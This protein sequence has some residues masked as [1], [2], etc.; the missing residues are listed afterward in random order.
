MECILCGKELEGDNQ[1]CGECALNALERDPLWH[2]REFLIGDSVPDVLSSNSV[3]VLSLANEREG[4]I[5]SSMLTDDLKVPDNPLNEDAERIFWRINMHLNHMGVPLYMEDTDDMELTIQDL[6]NISQI[7]KTSLSLHEFISLADEET[8]SRLATIYFYARDRLRYLR[9]MSNEDR[10]L[11]YGELSRRMET[12]LMEG[13]KMMPHRGHIFTNQAYLAYLSGDYR[14]SMELYRMVPEYDSNARALTG[15]GRAY[16][17]LEMSESAD[18]SYTSALRVDDR[19]VPAWEGKASVALKKKRWG[20]ALQFASRA[21]AI[22]PDLARLY[23]LKGDIF[24]EQGLY[25]EAD[26][27]YKKATQMKNGEVA[28]IKRAAA[29]YGAG[30]WG[31]ALQFIERY[32][33][34][35]P[36]DDAGLE[37]RERIKQAVD[38]GRA[39]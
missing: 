17:G 26:N 23:I 2:C 10:E 18:D 9:G 11:L 20:A 28:W 16:E 1:I 5:D 4:Y 35:F 6:G 38:E 24:A 3:I 32:L 8:L 12:Y 19:W 27:S 30:R 29:M 22:R 14:S 15:M 21:I 31:A 7:L 39:Y 36:D 25:S 37:W 34:H 13:E 33:F